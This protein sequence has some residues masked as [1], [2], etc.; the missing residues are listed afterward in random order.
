MTSRVADQAGDEAGRAAA[1]A[2][3][4]AED[5]SVAA[6]FD[7]RLGPAGAVSRRDLGD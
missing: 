1:F 5:Q 4:A 6:V 3:G 7:D 2:G